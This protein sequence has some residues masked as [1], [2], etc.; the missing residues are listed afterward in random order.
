METINYFSDTNR[1]L[2]SFGGKCP[3]KCLHCY[4]FSSNFR[5]TKNLFSIEDIV[6]DL[7]GRSPFEII[8]V[9]GYNENFINPD[10]GIELVEALFAEYK[11]HI[12]FTTRNI[13]NDKQI[14]K[15]SRIN[16]MMNSAG[17]NLFACVSISAYDSYKKIEIS[18]K[19]PTPIERIEFL[20]KL[21]RENIIT[22]LTLRP[23]FPNS[24][25][26]TT[27]YINILEK[28]YESCS[29]VI[30]SGIYIDED[31]INRIETFPKGYKSKKMAWSCF[32]YMRINKVDVS[33]ELSNINTFC[34]ERGVLVF[35]ESITA[36]NFFY[37]KIKSRFP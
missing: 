37:T 23:V 12:L 21:Y 30:T 18:D 13:F 29:A 15:I 8:Y 35:P 5:E 34:N 32:E 4:T 22:F 17:K 24:F 25:I 27:E 16:T 11:C 20:K 6:N 10:K 3:F 36:I 33:E 31:I 19:I 14:A 26:P 28:S 7:K 1:V 2:I 9:S